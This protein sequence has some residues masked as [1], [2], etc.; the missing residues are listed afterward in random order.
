MKNAAWK[1][2]LWQI[3]SQL[4]TA[5]E[6]VS[7]TKESKCAFTEMQFQRQESW[8]NRW[9]R[10][11][12]RAQHRIHFRD[13]FWI[14]TVDV[15]LRSIVRTWCKT[16]GNSISVESSTFATVQ[17]AWTVR[18]TFRPQ[19][20]VT[21]GGDNTV[22]LYETQRMALFRPISVLTVARR[23]RGSAKHRFPAALRW[24]TVKP[25][26]MAMNSRRSH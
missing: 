2:L 26:V 6:R 14:S 5:N 22:K 17:R 11:K 18:L 21:P 4:C 20:D 13:V 1:V 12:T 25:K 24:L 10:T 8:N 16:Q 15:W 3:S 23:S 9:E 19:K 7:L